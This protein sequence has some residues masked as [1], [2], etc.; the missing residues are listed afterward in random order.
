[1]QNAK[2]FSKYLVVSCRVDIKMKDNDKDTLLL[3]SNEEKEKD[4]NMF[5]YLMR[6]TAFSQF[7]FVM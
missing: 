1:M 5:I 2:L 6:E 4:S 3:K 7:S